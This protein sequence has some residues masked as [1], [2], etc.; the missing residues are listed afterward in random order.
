MENKLLLVVDTQV[1]FVMPAGALYVPGAEAIIEPGIAFLA[2]LDSRDYAAALFTFDSHDESFAGSPE[3]VGDPAAGVPGFPMHC[4]VGTPGWQNV[5]NPALV[6]EPIGLFQLHKGVFD[7]WEQQAGK[8]PV[9]PLARA[10]PTVTPGSAACDRDTFFRSV[11]PSEV[12]TA[13]V[14]GV[15]SDF[16]VK[17]AVNGLLERGYAVEIVAHLTRGIE[18][19]MA[20][21]IADDFPGR[22][23]LI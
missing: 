21:V 14:I 1:D 17:W 9:Q 22:V 8:V 13:T 20:A 7:M 6:P 15:A 12:R 2:Q 4:A 23:K 5:F 11:L 3:N 16:C 18:R 19:D 10:M